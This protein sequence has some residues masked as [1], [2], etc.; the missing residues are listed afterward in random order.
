[1]KRGWGCGGRREGMGLWGLC[2]LCDWFVRLVCV[3]LCCFVLFCSVL[4]FLFFS[5]RLYL[6]FFV[7]V[8]RPWSLIFI[9]IIFI[10]D[11]I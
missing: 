1:M 2:G 5:F 6:L 9:F 8:E 10:F 4:S 11:L 7:Y 3:G